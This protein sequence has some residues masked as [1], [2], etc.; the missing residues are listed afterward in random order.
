MN[1]RIHSLALPMLAGIALTLGIACSA[2]D[3]NNIVNNPK[4]GGADRAVVDG[5][6]PKPDTGNTPQVDGGGVPVDDSSTTPPAD[7]T[8]P[9]KVLEKSWTFDKA[10]DATKWALVYSAP[11]APD[12]G[13]TIFDTTTLIEHDPA[14]G[15]PTPPNGSLKIT[16]PFSVT[17]KE[18]E[19]KVH[20]AITFDAVDKLDLTGKTVVVRIK[21]DSGFNPAGAALGGAKLFVKSGDNYRWA[22]GEMMTLDETMGWLMLEFSVDSPSYVDS[23]GTGAAFDAKDIRMLGIEIVAGSAGAYTQGVFHLDTVG[24]Y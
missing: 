12:G 22:N 23:A 7:V 18:Y 11:E 5:V 16:V 14:T 1:T 8:E 6:A 13:K 24:Y 21:L 9:D 3:D 4:D 2:G 17:T 19:Q 20:L 15:M 10:E